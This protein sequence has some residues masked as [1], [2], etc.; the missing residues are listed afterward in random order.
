MHALFEMDCYAS[1]L[2]SSIL[3]L[4]C[5]CGVDYCYARDTLKLGEWI[6]DNGTT[7]VSCG[8]RFELGFFTPIRSSSHERYVGIW[9]KQDRHTV[10]WVANQEYAIL[11]GSTGTF[12][13]GDDG[14]LKVS[15]TTGG[16]D[17][18]SKHLY[19]SSTNRT[20]KLMDSGNLV[21]SANDDQYE[22][23]RNPSDTFLPGMKM[24][25]FLSLTSWKR[26]GDPR[27]GQFKFRKYPEEGS[28]IISK[29]PGVNYW[30]SS[31]NE[32]PDYILRECR[33]NTGI[34]Q[35]YSRW[36]RTCRIWISDLRD[37][38]EEYSGGINLSVRVA[39]LDTDFISLQ[40]Q[41]Q[42]IASLVA[43]TSSPIR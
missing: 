40:N 15:D 26:D 27:W 21:F 43:Q 34:C 24:D 17:Y 25:Y 2:L 42:G 32:M 30:R 31:S 38:Q 7:L 19:S 1:W 29:D 37:L 35:A 5:S 4:L 16:G 39:K 23:F 28:Y 13:I 18:W 9:Y 14:N 3:F 8:G 20:V 36:Y 33:N 10:V 12:G 11:N 6:T 22:G 41:L